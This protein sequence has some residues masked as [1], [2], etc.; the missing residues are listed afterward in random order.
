M[1]NTF[2]PDRHPMASNGGEAFVFEVCLLEAPMLF[3]PVWPGPLPLEK[4]RLDMTRVWA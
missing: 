3:G 2:L 1:E 4:S